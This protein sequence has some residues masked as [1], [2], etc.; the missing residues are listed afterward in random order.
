[1]RADVRRRDRHGA[2]ALDQPRLEVLVAHRGHQRPL[3]GQLQ[4]ADGGAEHLAQDALPG[5]YG[6]DR[7]LAGR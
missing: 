6:P 3:V 7:L 1:M 4:G 2:L 5:R